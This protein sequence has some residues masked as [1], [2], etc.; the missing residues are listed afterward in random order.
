MYTQFK[1]INDIGEK[2]NLYVNNV[3]TSFIELISQYQQFNSRDGSIKR[4]PNLIEDNVVESINDN[5]HDQT[6]VIRDVIP[7]NTV[8]KLIDEDGTY[9]CHLNRDFL[10]HYYVYEPY[11]NYLLGA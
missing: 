11:E 4:L 5:N 2:H 9:M 7:E 1:Y 10:L 8:N 6:T 3:N